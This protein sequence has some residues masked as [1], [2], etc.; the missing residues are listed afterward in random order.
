MA[1]RRLAVSHL[2][3]QELEAFCNYVNSD[4]YSE[5]L[6]GLVRNG[7]LIGARLMD[8]LVATAGWITA[9]D[10][11]STARMMAVFVSP[12]YAFNG[13]GRVVLDAAEAQ[14]RQAGFKLFTIRAPIG[15]IGFFAK[16]GYEVASHG[17][18]ALPVDQS[19][20]VGFMRKVAGEA[21]VAAGG[22]L[23]H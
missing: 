3:E 21:Q 18:W 17:V 22:V 13:L 19:I 14:A 23:S 9:N 5:R 8:E 7:R 2:S 16:Q 15:A 6:A 4:D 10:S 11:G 20:P 12:L 1:I